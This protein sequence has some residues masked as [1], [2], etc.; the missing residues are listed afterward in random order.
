MHELII[1]NGRIV[2]GTGRDIFFT[3]IAVNN[4][5][6]SHI[7]KSEIEAVLEIDAQGMV[8]APGFIDIHSH[9][10]VSAPYYRYMQSSLMQGVTTL[11]GG[12]CGYMPAPCD[13]YWTSQFIEM[14][15]LQKFADELGVIPELG[16]PESM[17]PLIKERFG[18]DFDWRDFAGYVR[19]LRVQGIGVNIMAFAGH[20]AIRSQVL[21][22]DYKR[23]A[24]DTEISAM[25]EYLEEA[26]AAGACGMSVG[27]DYAPGMYADRH[28]ILKLLAT[29][30]RYGGIF[31]THWRRTGERTANA[32]RRSRIDGIV[33]ALELAAE[34]EV[35]L[36]ISH[37]MTGYEIYPSDNDVL[38][39]CS[40]DETLAMIDAYR[41]RGLTGYHGVIP[42]I[43]G[44]ILLAPDLGMPFLKQMLECG[45]RGA[46]AE[47]LHDVSYL[48]AL[49]K[50]VTTG[51][52]Y[53]V[54]P[55]IDPEWDARCTILS[56]KFDDYYKRSLRDISAELDMDSVS[57]LLTLLREDPYT[58]VFRPMQGV[59]PSNIKR[60]ISDTHATIGTDSFSI[61][62]T[63][64]FP[65]AEDMPLYYPNPN[66]YSGMFHYLLEYPEMRLESTI[67]KL[68]GLAASIMHLSDRGILA[69]GN[70]ADIVIFDPQKLELNESLTDPRRYPVGIEH[71]IV[72]GTAAVCFGEPMLTLSG[73]FIERC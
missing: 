20:G 1:K 44:G 2:D 4:G 27:F 71:V 38:S 39:V 60:L 46:F 61:D 28:E 50:N 17:A 35:Q 72:N 31:A 58:K 13:R 19:K 70:R 23:P 15:C 11:V 3:D 48:E 18:V 7:G 65:F 5:R 8:V 14:E 42:N 49:K 54:N 34:A 69:C 63:T 33:E 24:I 10:D 57:G 40:A 45:S 66:T 25:N 64:R 32:S 55:L 59:T 52:I 51:S 43:T 30:K 12:Q 41:K 26:M 68:T 6:I 29:V 37:L 62:L 16:L 67:H 53:D 9:G 36:Q 56:C 73:K 21:D 22:Y 47:K